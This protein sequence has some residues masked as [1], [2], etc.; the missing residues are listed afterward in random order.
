[1]FTILAAVIATVAVSALLVSMPTKS[2]TAV[3]LP[4]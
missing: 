3:V 1:M 4:A 2:A